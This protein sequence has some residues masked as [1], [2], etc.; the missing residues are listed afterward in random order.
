ME[1]VATF[2]R[3]SHR[4]AASPQQ[5]KPVATTAR[6]PHLNKLVLAGHHL[7]LLFEE[8]KSFNLL[9]LEVECRLP[10]SSCCCSN[11]RPYHQHNHWSQQQAV[12]AHLAEYAI[13]S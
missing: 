3:F 8:R 10:L 13:I 1:K 12:A 4:K 7:D 11:E 6:V 9:L 2:A 5:D